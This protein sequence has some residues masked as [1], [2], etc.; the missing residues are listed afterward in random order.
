MLL[1]LCEINA[2]S[3]L[4]NTWSDLWR[5]R[6]VESEHRNRNGA[7][8]SL[9]QDSPQI[10]HHTK[11]NYSYS[12][13]WEYALCSSVGLQLSGLCVPAKLETLKKI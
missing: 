7:P 13:T 12:V 1:F 2:G 5:L 9:V 3:S 11:R 6:C 8:R 10:N 4:F